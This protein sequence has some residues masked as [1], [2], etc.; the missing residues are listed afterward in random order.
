MNGCRQGMSSK[1][2]LEE[3]KN[4]QSFFTFVDGCR[5]GRSSKNYLE[6]IKDGHLFLPS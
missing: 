6:E 3:I 5:Q 2:Y 1:N 4:G